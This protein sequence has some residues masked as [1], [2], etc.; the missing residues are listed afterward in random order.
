MSK[1]DK[2]YIIAFISFLEH[3]TLLQA[4]L[5]TPTMFCRL[6]VLE[7]SGSP[8]VTGFACRHTT[9]RSCSRLQYCLRFWLSFL[10][11]PAKVLEAFNVPADRECNNLAYTGR[12]SESGDFATFFF[13]FGNN[14]AD[15][16]IAILLPHLRHFSCNEAVDWSTTYVNYEESSEFIAIVLFHR[17]M[18]S[19][20]GFETSSLLVLH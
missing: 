11:E 20:P 17:S 15:A 9:R 4:A 14:G 12:V 2:R 7:G 16:A 13:W 3:T 5:Y 18:P 19:R 1:W 10:K 8:D 6:F